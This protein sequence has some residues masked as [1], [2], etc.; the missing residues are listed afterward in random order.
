MVADQMTSLLKTTIRR[1]GESVPEI[2]YVTDAGKIETAYWKNTLRR[3][4][5]DCVRIKITRVVDY[6]HAA[7]RL[8]TIADECRRIEVWQREIAASGLAEARPG[9]VAGTRR[10]RPST[11]FDCQDPSTSWVQVVSRR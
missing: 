7:S 6:Y 1:C 11:S 2:V 3:F 8:T 9:P 4:F 10:A 5:V